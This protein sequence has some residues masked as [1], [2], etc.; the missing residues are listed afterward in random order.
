M[1]GMFGIFSNFP[2]LDSSQF[3]MPSGHKDFIQYYK[4][5]SNLST[6]NL[7]SFNTDN[8]INM[9]FMLYGCKS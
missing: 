5:C 6:L 2:Y 1:E 8:V 9:S 7:L 3:E 4:G